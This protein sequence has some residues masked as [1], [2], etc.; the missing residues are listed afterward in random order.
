MSARVFR[1]LPLTWEPQIEFQAPGFT[2]AQS[3]VSY[4]RY[5]GSEPVNGLTPSLSL[6]LSNK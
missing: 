6:L 2:L 1:F 5:L 4:C 3:S